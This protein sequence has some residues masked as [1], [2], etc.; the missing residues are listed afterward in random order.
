MTGDGIKEFFAA[1]DASREEYEKCD[2]SFPAFLSVHC[3]NRTAGNIFLSCKRRGRGVINPYKRSR[4]T[5]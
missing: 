2:H 4:K 5:P 3:S 1:V